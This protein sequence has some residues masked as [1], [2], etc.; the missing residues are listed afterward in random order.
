MSSHGQVVE[1]CPTQPLLVMDR[2]NLCTWRCLALLLGELLA[3][4]S[5][6]CE[7]QVKAAQ[8]AEVELHHLSGPLFSPDWNEE[9]VYLGM[10]L[11]TYPPSLLALDK[12]AQR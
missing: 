10:A 11:Q 8:A 1:V 3:S 2:R 5:L 7:L 9:S 12:W 6:K 4:P